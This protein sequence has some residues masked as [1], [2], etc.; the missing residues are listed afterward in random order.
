MK[1]LFVVDMQYDFIDGSLGS[2]RAKNI[3]LPNV[4]KKLEECINDENYQIFFTMDTHHEDYLNTLEGKKLPVKH[5][6]HCSDGWLIHKDLK[7]IVVSQKDDHNLM[8]PYYL[9][10]NT[11]GMCNI[12]KVFVDF[13]E[14]KDEI[15]ICGLCT[16]I[17]VISNALILR[18]YFPDTKIT[19]IEKCCGG[20]SDEAHKAALEVMRSC[21]IDVI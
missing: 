13:D 11:F 15:E 17:C 21:Q 2:D 18:A 1:Y 16:D 6:I 8:K 4:A 12:N 10:K 19:C 7:E 9:M 3:V 14:Y 5:C 20:T